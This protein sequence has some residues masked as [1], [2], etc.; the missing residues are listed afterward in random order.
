MK[1]RQMNQE[2]GLLTSNLN[3]VGICIRKSK[4]FATEA[5]EKEY[6]RQ[7]YKLRQESL[8]PYINLKKF[9]QHHD[10]IFE[11]IKILYNKQVINSIENIDLVNKFLNE[12]KYFS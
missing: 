8:K 12:L 9:H 7:Q 2:V 11:L 4:K 6:K 10:K 3:S 5:E 1:K